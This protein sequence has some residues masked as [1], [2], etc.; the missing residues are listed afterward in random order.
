MRGMA[1]A[2]AAQVRTRSEDCP[3]CALW[4][5]LSA[6]RACLACARGVFRSRHAVRGALLLCVRRIIM[7]RR[8]GVAR[9][10]KLGREHFVCAS[11]VESAIEAA[12]VVFFCDGPSKAR[13]NWPKQAQI[14]CKCC[15]R[16]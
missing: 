8:V 3:A 16:V 15:C 5:V 7:S 11:V 4:L 10:N 9:A 2:S 6:F 12:V 14:Y 1:S 13:A